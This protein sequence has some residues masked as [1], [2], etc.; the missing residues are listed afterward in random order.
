MPLIIQVEVKRN[1]EDFK[2]ASTQVVSFFMIIIVLSAL[3]DHH[4]S[5]ELKRKQ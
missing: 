3:R 4:T 5:A 1:H 2:T